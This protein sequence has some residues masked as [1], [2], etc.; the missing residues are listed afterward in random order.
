MSDPRSAV[1]GRGYDVIGETFV[2]WRDRIV[3]DPRDRWRE[4]LASRLPH[5]ARVLELGCGSGL[6]DT[7]LLAERFRVTAVD[8]SGEQVR[9]TRANAPSAEV[10]EADFT[11]LE[12][13][14]AS[15]EAVAAFYS[16][17]H[18]PRDL[19]PGLFACIR[20]WL[21]ADGLFLTALGTSDN[22]G[23]YGDFLGAT[24][25]FSSFPPGTNR[26]LLGE[27]GFEVV[28]DEIVTFREPDGDATFQWVLCRT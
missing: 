11:S 12:L 21:V 8:V 10:V 20:S 23:W 6:P 22:E 24:S 15:F 19:L 7:K 13:P 1:V 9:R 5:G 18:V 27:A 25:Y 17:N 4:E 14:P 26:R 28:L 2:E 3:G 16:F